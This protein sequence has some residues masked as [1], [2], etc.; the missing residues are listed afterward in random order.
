MNAHFVDLTSLETNRFTVLFG[1]R[2]IQTNKPSSLLIWLCRQFL[3]HIDRN[4]YLLLSLRCI[5]I[6]RL[7]CLFLCLLG[8][9]SLP[10]GLVSLPSSIEYTYTVRDL[11]TNYVAQATEHL[12]VFQKPHTS[13]IF[14]RVCDL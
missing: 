13:L 14:L 7:L 10:S 11:I 3:L 5:I 6:V 4:N 12:C 9:L 2:N 1:R 8:L